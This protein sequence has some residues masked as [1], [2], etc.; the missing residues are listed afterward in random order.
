MFDPVVEKDKIMQIMSESVE[1]ENRKDIEG[2]LDFYED[3][4]YILA[5]GM[6]LIKGRS[7]FRELLKTLFESLI[8]LDNEVLDVQFS[9]NGNMA[10]V[11]CSYHMVLKGP[12][13]NV[14]D[15]GKFLAILSKKSGEWKGVATSYNADE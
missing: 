13:G 15:I 3:D 1:V 14:D 9:K 4:C 10:Y 2:T 6:K 7:H 12:E 11:I 8:H 5:P